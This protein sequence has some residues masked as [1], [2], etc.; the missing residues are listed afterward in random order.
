MRFTTAFLLVSF[1]AAMTGCGSHDPKE[2]HNGDR[3]S[4]NRALV[5]NGRGF[6]NGLVSPAPTCINGPVN[7]AANQAVGAV[8]AA[9]ARTEQFTRDVNRTAEHVQ[10]EVQQAAGD[11]AQLSND[12]NRAVN[13]AARDLDR[14]K[15]AFR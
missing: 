11:A 14:L 4:H 9:A 3:D 15:N 6:D 7:Q 1:A 5:D 10:N 13:S 12:A 2:V 8:D